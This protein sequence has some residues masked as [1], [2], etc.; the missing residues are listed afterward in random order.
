[1]KRWDELVPPRSAPAGQQLVSGRLQ[2]LAKCIEGGSGLTQTGAI[3]GTPSYMAPEQALGEGKR[4][5]P[6]AVEGAHLTLGETCLQDG[7]PHQAVLYLEKVVQAFPGSRQAELAQQRLLQ[8]QG[9]PTRP[10]DFKD[11]REYTPTCFLRFE[12]YNTLISS[13]QWMSNRLR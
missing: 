12:P 9:Q 11:E 10:I 4:V 7:Q 2:R 5:G 6:A 8:F 1:M 13:L 3:M